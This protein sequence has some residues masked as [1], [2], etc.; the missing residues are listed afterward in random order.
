MDSDE[1]LLTVFLLLS[2]LVTGHQDQS[3]MTEVQTAF[4]KL[5]TR[6]TVTRLISRKFFIASSC[7][8]SFKPYT[9]T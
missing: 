7:R 4:K 6:F 5:E 1:Y 8:E 3:L 2:V 9:V